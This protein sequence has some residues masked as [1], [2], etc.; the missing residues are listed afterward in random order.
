MKIPKR[1]D[2]YGQSW[3]VQYKWNLLGDDGAH[4]DG[5]CD[6]KLNII[7]IDRAIPPGGRFTIFIHELIHAIFHELKIGQTS[8]HSEVEEIMVT[9]IEEYFV[10]K[11]AMR[12]R[13]KSRP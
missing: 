3:T 5:L 6:D 10:E 9:G 7:W 4:V 8:V 13:G 2:V 11:F 12:W 1:L